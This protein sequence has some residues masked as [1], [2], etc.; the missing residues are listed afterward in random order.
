MDKR[1]NKRK[2]ITDEIKRKRAKFVQGKKSE[3]KRENGEMSTGSTESKAKQNNG[4][5]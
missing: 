4:E 5:V 1:R 2:G 3:V